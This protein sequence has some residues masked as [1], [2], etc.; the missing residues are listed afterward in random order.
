MLAP[1]GA[2]VSTFWASS[3]GHP[4]LSDADPTGAPTASVRNATRT[5]SIVA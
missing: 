5:A 4:F 2:H 3:D 1:L